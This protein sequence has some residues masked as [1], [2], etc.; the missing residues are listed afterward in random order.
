MRTFV[1]DFSCW[2]LAYCYWYLAT[3]FL[4]RSIDLGKHNNARQSNNETCSFT[5][6][7]TWSIRDKEIEKPGNDC[8]SVLR[9]IVG[10]VPQLARLLF[11]SIRGQPV[12]RNQNQEIGPKTI[13]RPPTIT[14]TAE[15]ISI[16]AT[17]AGEA[18]PT[19]RVCD[20]T[21]PPSPP[22]TASS[23]IT[24]QC[25]PHLRRGASIS[26]QCSRIDR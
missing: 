7:T 2:F 17:K 16:N 22:N 19:L 24:Q 21:P 15:E 20:M 14:E 18:P 4:S 26:R 6:G 1:L 3:N 9:A 8:I 23:P 10:L 13:N 12:L 5:C 25:R 11:S